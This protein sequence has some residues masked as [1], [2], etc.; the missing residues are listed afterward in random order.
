MK[1]CGEY[2]IDYLAK[3][4]VVLNTIIDESKIDPTSTAFLSIGR[5]RKVTLYNYQHSIDYDND[6]FLK[7]FRKRKQDPSPE[8]SCS[9]YNNGR[10][11]KARSYYSKQASGMLQHLGLGDDSKKTPSPLNLIL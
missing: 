2:L 10:Q 8:N 4:G 9:L 5:I 6:M 3:C 7:Y 11:T 1:L